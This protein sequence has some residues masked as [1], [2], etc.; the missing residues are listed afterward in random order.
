MQTLL[1]NTVEVE[2][3]N[4]IKDDARVNSI[5]TVRPRAHSGAW[6][7]KISG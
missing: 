2:W 7:K 4:I 1:R 6:S 5:N 3:D